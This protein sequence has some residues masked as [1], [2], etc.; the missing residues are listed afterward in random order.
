MYA[1]RSYYVWVLLLGFVYGVVHAIGPGHGKAVVT[2]YFLSQDKK[3]R[4]GVI[5][6][7]EIGLSHVTSAIIFVYCTR[8]TSYN[9]CYTK[10]LRE[11]IHTKLCSMRLRPIKLLLN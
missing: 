2:S 5:M 1:I 7:F 3:W 4:D 6:G 9:V 10:L 11:I 8:I